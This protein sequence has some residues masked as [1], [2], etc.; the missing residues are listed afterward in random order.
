MKVKDVMHR[1]V[2]PVQLNDTVAKAARMMR[3]YGVD[4][5]PVCDDG[6]VVGIVTAADIVKRIVADELQVDQ[7]FVGKAMSTGVVACNEE[8]DEEEAMS[9]M[10]RQGVQHLLVKNQMQ[11]ISGIVSLAAL[12]LQPS[13]AQSAD[14]AVGRT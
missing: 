6:K 1:G 11:R 4:A 13:V 2:E 8:D 9:L 7:A 10:E 12:I 5:I 3:K 14:S